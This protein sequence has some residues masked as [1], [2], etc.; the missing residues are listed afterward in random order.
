MIQTFLSYITYLLVTAFTPGPNNIMSL[1]TVSTE[2]WKKGR[3]VISGILTGLLMLIIFVIISCHELAKYI[4]GI[5]EYLKYIGAAYIFFLAYKIA[6]SKPGKENSQDDNKS[7]INFK[8]GF[9]LSISNMKV[10]LF[11]MTLFTA[12]IIPSGA[13]LAEMFLHGFVV[14]TVNVMSLS[15][16]GTAGGL[17]QK[18]LTKYYRPFNILMGII[19]AWCA[20][21]ILL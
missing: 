7:S 17:M 11:L 16:W 3:E 13:S 15:T 2:G 4:P 19:L 14:I 9:F 20:V 6:V 18:F 12:Y 8:S 5:V 21:K 10:I 1:Y